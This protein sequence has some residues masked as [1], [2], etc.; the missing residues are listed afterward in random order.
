MIE[1]TLIIIKPDGLSIENKIIRRYEKAVLK[2]VAKKTIKAY[3]DLLRKHYAAHVGKPF[4]SGLEKFM[5]EHPVVAFVL[6]GENAIERARE[7]TGATDPSK[8]AKGTI[9]GDLSKDSQEKADM[10]NRAI[11]NLV[12][13]SGSKEEAEKEI[14]LWFPELKR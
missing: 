6:E 13:A 12:H 11:R 3:R 8:A 7:I 5:M 9:R 2:V 14:E 10:E 4:Y 1:R